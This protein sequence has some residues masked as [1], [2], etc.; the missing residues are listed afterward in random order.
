MLIHRSQHFFN[1]LIPT[2]S[3]SSIIIGKYKISDDKHFQ[4]DNDNSKLKETLMR[5][6]AAVWVEKSSI[7]TK[8]CLQIFAPVAFQDVNK[9]WRLFDFREIQQE[10]IGNQ[11]PRDGEIEQW[12]TALGPSLESPSPVMKINKMST[13]IT[14]LI[15]HP[16]RETLCVPSPPT[17]DINQ[18]R[19][20]RKASSKCI[21]GAA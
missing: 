8:R 11:P 1:C 10:L 5:G 16:Y 4:D 20:E 19:E 15:H 12:K 6:D 14:C 7:S 2:K 18:I 21:H 3:L 9:F 13:E 17:D